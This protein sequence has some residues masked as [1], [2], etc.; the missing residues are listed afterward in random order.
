M[1]FLILISKSGELNE[2]TYMKDPRMPAFK[3]GKSYPGRSAV[4]S[5]NIL[6]PEPYA[7]LDSV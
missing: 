7:T 1:L 4:I 2:E 3:L 6:S 5:M